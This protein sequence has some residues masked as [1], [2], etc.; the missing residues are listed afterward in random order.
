MATATRQAMLELEGF[1]DAFLSK[2]SPN[3]LFEL[4]KS[5]EKAITA[6]AQADLALVASQIRVVAARNDLRIAEANNYISMAAG[7]RLQWDGEVL[8]N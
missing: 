6:T 3:E 2:R 8:S 7:P 4:A 1:V 5:W